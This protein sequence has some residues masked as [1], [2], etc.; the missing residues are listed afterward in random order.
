MRKGSV[1]LRNQRRTL[2]P[3][4]ATL[5]STLSPEGRGK[6]VFVRSEWVRSIFAVFAILTLALT[7]AEPAVEKKPEGIVIR[8]VKNWQA[9]QADVDKVLYSA[10]G[11]LFCNFPECKLNPIE[12]EP[13]G[14]PITLYRRGAAGQYLVRLDTGGT[15]WSQY[16]YQFSHELCHILCKYDE[17]DHHQKWFEESLCE[18]A[19][20][21][22]LRRMSKNWKTEPP[23]PNWKSYS[24]QLNKYAEERIA[25]AQ[26]PKEKTFDQWYGEN[27]ADL[28]KNAVDR[29]RNTV[30]AVALLDL[31]EKAPE[32]WESVQ[33]LNTAKLSKLHSFKDY[34][35]FWQ[36]NCPEKHKAFV[37][38]IAS[39]F[40]IALESEKK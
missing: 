13:K 31:F 37:A 12:V 9:Q 28:N 25:T 34:L 7:G 17:D 38:C 27:A 35:Q 20:L 15:F 1:Q 29:E 39:R 26:L 16:A 10:A 36:R 2:H 5:T 23:Y 3:A 33:W 40:A 22:V 18:L 11:E 8:A 4:F 21:Y 6:N 19:S 32:S 30:V 24:V 14:G